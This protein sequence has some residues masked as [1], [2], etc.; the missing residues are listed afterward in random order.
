M[1]QVSTTDVLVIWKFEKKRHK[2]PVFAW[3]REV[4][5][6]F[7]YRGFREFEG[8]RNQDMLQL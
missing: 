4:S 2:I 5:F 7:S 8:V 6:V 1:L 3:G